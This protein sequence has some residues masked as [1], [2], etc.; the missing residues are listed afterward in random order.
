MYK[1]FMII[2]ESEKKV[3]ILY[4]KISI[5]EMIG[6]YLCLFLLSVQLVGYV[7]FRVCDGSGSVS[8]GPS[9]TGH[10]GL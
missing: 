10:S 1:Q 7:S 3:I 9:Y 4:K 6:V 8:S 5:S 2:I